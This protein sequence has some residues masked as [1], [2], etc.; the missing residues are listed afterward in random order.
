MP[1][2]SMQRMMGREGSD[3][4]DRFRDVLPL[5]RPPAPGDA[6]AQW[7][8]FV[9][10]AG[11]P[12]IY[13]DHA[14]T[15]LTGRGVPGRVDVHGRDT[16]TPRWIIEKLKRCP[17]K[18]SADAAR[19]VGD[20]VAYP[21][22]DAA[23]LPRYTALFSAGAT[24]DAAHTRRNLGRPARAVSAA[25]MRDLVGIPLEEI[26]EK[27][28]LV[29]VTPQSKGGG[30]RRTAQYTR[31]GRRMLHALGAWPW[32]HAR[33][34]QLPGDWYCRGTFLVPFSLWHREAWVLAGLAVHGA[35]PAH[36][37]AKVEAVA[38]GEYDTPREDFEALVAQW[39][40][41][42]DTGEFGVYAVAS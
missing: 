11:A 1:P 10:P 31:D 29:E 27:L 4:E 42:V 7:L 38:R 15:P 3:G 37:T 17:V 32:A 16:R 14:P 36:A 19:I 30:V 33:A 12:V 5:I 9:T 13:A 41:A 40:R 26:G 6:L 18:L 28:G 25:A 24:N 35:L 21:P 8:H 20:L 34:G 39:N 2:E 23:G 22:F